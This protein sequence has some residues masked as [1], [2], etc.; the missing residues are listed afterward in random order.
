MIDIVTR[1]I[2]VI[3]LTVFSVVAQ[4]MDGTIPMTTD[5]SAR[6][7][8]VVSAIKLLDKL[9]DDTPVSAIEKRYSLEDGI[10]GYQYCS[11]ADGVILPITDP[12][13]KSGHK[14]SVRLIPAIQDP[15]L[16]ESLEDYRPAV[17]VDYKIV[18]VN[19]SPWPFVFQAQYQDYDSLELD[20][21]TEAGKILVVKQ[22]EPSSYSTK[23]ILNFLK[24]DRQWEHLLS[25]DR[26]FWVFPEGFATNKIVRVRPRFAF[27]VY[28]VEGKFFRTL[29]EIQKGVRK[30]RSK[31]DREGELVGE[32]IDYEGGKA[33]TK[34]EERK[35]KA[36][37]PPAG[38]FAPAG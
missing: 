16:P 32:W 25:L 38:R 23:P 22:K 2:G 26:R 36:V 3:G 13:M 28:E 14:V 8:H 37:K 5:S 20:F 1:M 19:N 31:Y 15:S 4:D 27:G 11:P 35:M 7:N 17:K 24:P 34:N 6:S 18:L 21:M 12:S 30:E 29:D 9:D 33:V 10:M